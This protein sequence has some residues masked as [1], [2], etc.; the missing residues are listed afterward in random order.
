MSWDTRFFLANER[1]ILWDALVKEIKGFSFLNSQSRYAI[2]VALAVVLSILVAWLIQL[3]EAYWS[4][5][6]AFIASQGTLGTTFGKAL[7]RLIGTWVGGIAGF[8]CNV[9]FA[10]NLVFFILFGVG[11]CIVPFYFREI[12]QKFN[13]TWVLSAVT[14]II[15]MFSAL[16]APIPDVE[17]AYRICFERIS[18]VSLGVVVTTVCA[19]LIFP[20]LSA[21][22]ARKKLIVIY[23]NW[24]NL[25]QLVFE[26]YNGCDNQAIFNEAY[27]NQTK[28]INALFDLLQAVEY[29][30][31][32]WDI[33]LPYEALERFARELDEI[34][35]YC[36][37]R[38][39]SGSHQYNFKK[40][41]TELAKVFSFMSDQFEQKKLNFQL[42]DIDHL[43]KT[44]EGHQHEL[45]TN[46]SQNAHIMARML[47][48]VSKALFDYQHF[49]RN[50][51]R[52]ETKILNHFKQIIVYEGFSKFDARNI[53]NAVVTSLM[54]FLAPLFWASIGSMEYEQ[55]AITILVCMTL[56][57]QATKFKSVQRLMGCLSGA[58]LTL[59]VLSFD[60]QSFLMMGIAIFL[61]MY[62][63]QYIVA[64]D[65]K[66]SYFGLQA[67]IPIT[68]GLVNGLAPMDSVLPALE[69][70]SGIFLGVFTVIIIEAF[71]NTE[72]PFT[73]IKHNVYQARKAL[74]RS[75]E[76]L[77]CSSDL[78]SETTAYNLWRVRI[79]IADLRA[80]KTSDERLI[81]LS[82]LAISSLRNIYHCIYH[83]RL[84]YRNQS[85]QIN[86]QYRE[87]LDQLIHL[88]SAYELSIYE[89]R[90]HVKMAKHLS[91]KLEQVHE[92]F[93]DSYKT[94]ILARIANY[95][96]T[97]FETIYQIR[98]CEFKHKYK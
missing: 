80:I 29:E 63:F 65:A 82:Q 41:K 57:T 95:T 28:Q 60:I 88:L 79:N 55:I 96:H 5:M 68:I 78:Q 14:A 32:L 93:P 30:R 97:Y 45:F 51:E 92:Q 4:G 85:Y 83:V 16:S 8:F 94:E 49:G 24:E 59:L 21:R 72:T 58:V 35:V 69:R 6:S 75:L 87:L 17:S 43:Q 62:L 89:L 46:N 53:K 54:V 22:I 15:V 40:L 7:M 64:G 3:P 52:Q 37:E 27:I 66:V 86:V 10:D 71:L 26:K 61:S 48:F 67:C 77:K 76:A 70:L 98:A 39:E 23:R 50:T 2:R 73:L 74:I 47:K 44:I 42:P 9:F 31:K 34:L 38:L 13:Y 19:Y 33:K 20:N 56:K 91:H 18:E 84:Y 1:K 12:D 36:Y 90:K 81:E 11:I 25:F